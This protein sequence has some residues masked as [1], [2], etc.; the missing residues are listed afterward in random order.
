MQRRKSSTNFRKCLPLK[1]RCQLECQQRQ[2]PPCVC[3]AVVHGIKQLDNE[4]LTLVSGFY[5]HGHQTE[6]IATLYISV[7]NYTE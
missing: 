7:G 4:E 3:Y 2:V 6:E 5:H 1:T